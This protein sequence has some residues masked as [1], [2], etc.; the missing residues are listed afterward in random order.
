MEVFDCSADPIARRQRL[1][2]RLIARSA[3]K[4][5]A[6]SELSIRVLAAGD[7]RGSDRGT[8]PELL[9]LDADGNGFARLHIS[10]WLC[11]DGRL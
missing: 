10:G 6:L 7:S 2:R 8:S 1:L 3:V 5:C 4:E 11:G 9:S